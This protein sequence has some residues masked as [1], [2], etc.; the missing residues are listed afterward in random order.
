MVHEEKAKMEMVFIIRDRIR[1][2]DPSYNN[3][4]SAQFLYFFYNLVE[5]EAEVVYSTISNLSIVF[6]TPYIELKDTC[7][8]TCLLP[9]F[10]ASSYFF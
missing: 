7:L 8:E 2:N 5:L 3:I 10:N 9:N 6:S 1:W 4:I